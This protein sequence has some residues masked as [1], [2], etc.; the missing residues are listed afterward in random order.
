[1]SVRFVATL[2][3]GEALTDSEVGPVSALP[4]DRVQELTVWADGTPSS[5]TVKVDLALG[6]RVR[7][8]VRTS[9]PVGQPDVPPTRVPV[10]E[11]S[12]DGALVSRLYW[13]PDH[14][15]ILTAQDLY[16]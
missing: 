7:F 3:S 5:V 16:F 11:L 14:G 9:L 4:L 15:P 6:E 10:F 8:F 1:M 2:D 12:R 13:H